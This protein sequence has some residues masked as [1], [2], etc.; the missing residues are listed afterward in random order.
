MGCG[1]SNV[2][3]HEHTQLIAPNEIAQHVNIIYKSHIDGNASKPHIMI[4]GLGC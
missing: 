2:V 3:M 4:E 1:W